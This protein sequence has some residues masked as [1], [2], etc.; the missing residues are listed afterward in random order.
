MNLTTTKTQAIAKITVSPV[1]TAEQV[2]ATLATV[3]R[4]ARPGGELRG[5]STDRARRTQHLLN[6]FGDGVHCLCV[7]CGTQLSCRTLTQD[8]I[9]SGAQGGRYI[10]ANL[11]P[12]C[13]PCNRSR[14]DSDLGIIAL[15]VTTE[16]KGLAPCA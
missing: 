14:E 16:P 15:I 1:P 7:Y 10:L 5:N 9:V 11:L 13:W 2:V 6:E 3:A 4:S 8:R 12:A